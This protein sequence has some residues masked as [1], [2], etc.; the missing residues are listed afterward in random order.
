MKYAV[1]ARILG[2]GSVEDVKIRK[3]KDGEESRCEPTPG[4]YIWVDIFTDYTEAQRLAES[5]KKM[6]KKC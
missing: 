3:A 5:Y 2:D 4:C 1:E 6:E